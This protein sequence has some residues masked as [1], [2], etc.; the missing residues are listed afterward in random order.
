MT[1]RLLRDAGIGAGM[2]VL[3]VGCGPGTVS[4]M[5]ASLV[6]PDGLVV[7]LDRSRAVIERAQAAAGVNQRFVVGELLNPPAGPFDAV[8]GRRVLMYQPDVIEALAALREVLVPGGLAVFQEHDATSLS[9]DERFPL[10]QEVHRWLW[11]TIEREDANPAMG[12]RLPQALVAAGFDVHQ[13]RAEA[14]VQ[15]KSQRHVTVEIVRAMISRIVAQGVATEAEID[16]PALD[17][18]LAEELSDAPYVGELVVGVWARPRF[19]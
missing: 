13:V 5:A 3:D 11:T 2:K 9:A 4:R 14:V 7:G 15:T 1:E 16:L 12:L 6:G 17:T 18:R 8:V 10:H 19:L